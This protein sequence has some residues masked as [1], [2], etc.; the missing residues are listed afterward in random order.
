MIGN[1]PSEDMIAGEL[2]IHT[3]LVIDYLEEVGSKDITE[4][5][6]GSLVEQESYL[7]SMPCL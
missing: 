7:F 4:F 1:S 2:G 6:R 3:F 5:R